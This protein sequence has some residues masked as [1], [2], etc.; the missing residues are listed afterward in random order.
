MP[1]TIGDVMRETRGG[2]GLPDSQGNIWPRLDSAYVLFYE[3]TSSIQAAVEVISARDPKASPLRSVFPKVSI[4]EDLHDK[5]SFENENILRLLN[6]HA[7]EH[8]TFV[9]SLLLKVD[10]LT[11]GQP[12]ADHVIERKAIDMAFQHLRQVTI[13]SQ[14]LDHLDDI[15]ALLCKLACVDSYNST[16]IISSI[17]KDAETQFQFSFNKKQ[18]VRNSTNRLIITS[19]AFL[20]EKHPETYGL[21]NSGIIHQVMQ[22]HTELRDYLH[23]HRLVWPEYFGLVVQL[24]AFGPLETLFLL[25][26]GYLEFC[27]EVLLISYGHELQMKHSEIW[28]HKDH[29]RRYPMLS[30]VDCILAL[31]TEHVDL[32]DLTR[33]TEH[34]ETDFRTSGNILLSNDEARLIIAADNQRRNYLLRE[35]CLA[36]SPQTSGQSTRTLAVLLTNAEAV[37]NRL[38]DTAFTSIE[39]GIQ[40]DEA[41]DNF[42]AAATTCII[43]G[44]LEKKRTTRL[45][46]LVARL[47]ADFYNSE[48][49]LL[50]FMGAIFPAE[51]SQVL[52]TL[53]FWVT[54]LLSCDDSDMEDR[55]LEWLKNTIFTKEPVKRPFDTPRIQLITAFFRS[56]NTISARIMD[57]SKEAYDR[58]QDYD[59]H[60][61]LIQGLH[62]C[63]NWLQGCVQKLEQE[64][65]I[66]SSSAASSESTEE[67]I[68]GENDSERHFWPT[69]LMGT[70]METAQDARNMIEQ[71]DHFT[72]EIR[73]WPDMEVNE[74]PIRRQRGQGVVMDLT[75]GM[76]KPITFYSYTET[77]N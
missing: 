32:S 41:F 73:G 14:H 16:M 55:V 52:E 18:A 70:L 77:C 54:D 43:K 68:S 46:Q 12:T 74:L 63:I 9:K 56:L 60:E 49:C 53:K 34:R 72:E 66:D 67:H 76:L 65:E 44:R 57:I 33:Q 69:Q 51:P 35:A 27:L 71:Y 58:R 22:S 37:D 42:A 13:N 28:F 11:K 59:T 29:G 64:L 45:V 25:E 62:D 61:K 20:R 75:D 30:L 4:P 19:L 26:H 15:T 47:H 21:E 23:G 1:C 48:D 10:V 31:L 39:N 50:R 3:R 24:A 40:T 2:P 7:P 38:S 36:T 6:I 17:C 8:A 5:I